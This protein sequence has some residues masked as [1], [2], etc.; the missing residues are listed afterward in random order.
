LVWATTL[1]RFVIKDLR[2]MKPKSI[3][4]TFKRWFSEAGFGELTIP[5]FRFV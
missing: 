3:T 2:F 4:L 1:I 5:V